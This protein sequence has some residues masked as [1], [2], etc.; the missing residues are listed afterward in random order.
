M[1]CKKCKDFRELLE[2]QDPTVKKPGFLLDTTEGVDMKKG[3]TLVLCFSRRWCVEPFFKAF[4]KLRIPVEDC[5]LLIYC[6]SDSALLERDLLFHAEKYRK[7]FKSLRLY[8]SYRRGRG[9]ISNLP[10]DPALQANSKSAQW[11]SG[12]APIASASVVPEGLTAYG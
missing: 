11:Q 8:Q 12:T 4:D 1:P 10:S 5:H 9:T 2:K 6:N 3:F 7:V